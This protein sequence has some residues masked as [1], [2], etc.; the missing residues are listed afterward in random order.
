MKLKKPIKNIVIFGDSYSTFEG[1]IPNGYKAW[2][3]GEGG[4]PEKTDVFSV[5]KTW[6]Y[7]LAKEL[8]L[9]IVRNDSWSGSTICHTGYGG[10]DLSFGKSFVSRILKLESVGFFNEKIDTVL[11]FGGTNDR[12]A[13][14]PL[15]E[16]KFSGIE[17][18]DLYSVLPAISFFAGKLAEKLPNANV[19]FIINTGLKPEIVEAMKASAEHY[20]AAYLELSDIDKQC[21]H[22]NVSGMRGICE[23]VKKFLLEN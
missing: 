10:E 20:G 19:I 9:N 22:P 2:Y 7:Q 6:W 3:G 17:R 1:F 5:D 4:T 12:W 8:D 18:E 16:L 13:D 23:Q 11:I 21:G 15:G 14:A